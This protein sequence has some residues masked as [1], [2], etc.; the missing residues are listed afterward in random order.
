LSMFIIRSW[1]DPRRREALRTM[2][3]RDF[4]VTLAMLLGPWLLLFGFNV[5]RAIYDDHKF[6]VAAN[7]ET[8]ERLQ[9]LEQANAASLPVL[10]DASVETIR[11]I[12]MSP[13]PGAR[14]AQITV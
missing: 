9:S 10:S 8:V 13:T 11:A 14:Q 2:T 3:R 5:L 1:R 7:R 4:G 12:L 6:L